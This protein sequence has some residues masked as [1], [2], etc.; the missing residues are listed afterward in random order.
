VVKRGGVADVRGSV[1]VKG[2]LEKVQRVKPTIVSI[3]TNVLK[4]VFIT[5]FPSMETYGLLIFLGRL[6]VAAVPSVTKLMNGLSATEARSVRQHYILQ[7]VAVAS[8][9]K[10]HLL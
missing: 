8:L 1:D 9:S 2:L 5:S 6:C 3:E 4:D 7:N 10:R